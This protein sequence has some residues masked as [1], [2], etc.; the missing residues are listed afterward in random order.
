MADVFSKK[1]RSQVMSAIRSKGN[2]A[3]ELKLASILR[4]RG[5]R[6]WRRHQRVFG[7]PDFV[8]RGVRLAL[9]VDGCFWHGCPKH[10]RKPES[11]RGYWLPKLERNQHRDRVVTKHLRQAGWRVVRLWAHDLDTPGVVTRKLVSGLSVRRCSL[12][13]RP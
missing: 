3:T 11:N 10:G 9:F 12:I 5:F 2:K 4:A 1:K 13:M 7:N 8:F 6:G